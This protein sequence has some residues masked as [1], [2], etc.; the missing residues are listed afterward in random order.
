MNS[1][2]NAMYTED[3]F[4]CTG[5]EISYCCPEPRVPGDKDVNASTATRLS[6]SRRSRS[7]QRLLPVV[8]SRRHGFWCDVHERGHQ[9]A[10]VIAA[11]DERCERGGRPT[12]RRLMDRPRRCVDGNALL[13]LRSRKTSRQQHTTAQQHVQ[14]WRSN[15]SSRWRTP[16]VHRSRTMGGCVWFVSRA[17]N[18]RRKVASTTRYINKLAWRTIESYDEV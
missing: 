16:T 15:G 17:L 18:P 13:S 14:S 10:Q 11:T 9:C 3:R 7:E 5:T 4:S 8:L 2:K 6:C 1:A 12:T